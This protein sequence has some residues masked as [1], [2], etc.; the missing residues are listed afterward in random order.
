MDDQALI[1]QWQAEEQQPFAGWDFSY[2]AGRYT[3][4]QPPWSYEALV[5]ELAG[6]ADSLLDMGTGGGEKL[7]EIKR[8]LPARTM[9]TEGYAPNIPIARANLEPQGIQVVAY[10]TDTEVRMPF[11][12]NAFACIIDRHEAFDAVEVAR[13]LRPGGV[14]LTQ[15]V[16][17]RDLADLLALFGLQSGYLHV[18][19]AN[20][21]QG[22]ADAGLII[23]R[24]EDCSGHSTFSDMGALVYYLHAAPWDAPEKF[25]VERCA[26]ALLR[27]YHNNRPL[28]FTI[29]RFIIQARKP[30][31]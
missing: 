24:T 30:F 10:S 8:A 7:L 12:D 18:N 15:Q 23:E 13:I 21:A 6:N 9:A 27:I 22:L 14:F 4:D 19:L 25:S 26:D 5:R 11:D 2:L 1:A 17:G 16:D 31:A 29:R 20:C 28:S 3:E